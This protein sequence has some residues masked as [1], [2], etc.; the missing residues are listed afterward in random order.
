MEADAGPQKSRISFT[1]VDGWSRYPVELTIDTG[2]NWDQI[3]EAWYQKAALISGWND[4]KKLPRTAS[5]YVMKTV[6]DRVIEHMDGIDVV[7]AYYIP[8]LKGEAPVSPPKRKEAIPP[9]TEAKRL[10]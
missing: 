8:S 5:A 9:P 6:N 4:A 3:V 10:R 7:F 1:V 2:M